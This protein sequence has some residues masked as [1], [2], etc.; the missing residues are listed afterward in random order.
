MPVRPPLRLAAFV[1]D[2]VSHIQH[3]L[4]R[5]P[6]ARQHEFDD[7]RMWIDLAKTLERGRF[8]TLFFADV[9]GLYGPA[10]GDYTVNAREG[11]QVPNADPSILAAALAT[12]TEHLGLAFT[13]SVLQAHP[14]EFA[15]RVSTLD[16]LSRGRIGWNIV[17]S[18]LDGAA[19]NFGHDRLEEHDERYAWAQEYVD[20]VAKLW[21]GSWDDD[22]F[23][24]DK[25]AG[26]VSDASGIH[27]IDHVGQRYRVAG[28]HLS[29]PSPQRTPVL[30]QA[31]SSPAGRAFAARNAEAQFILT[32]TR[33]KTAEL[34]ASTRADVAAAGRL[35]EDLLFFLGLTFVIGST[36][37]EA[38]RRSAEIDELLSPDGFLLHSN[39]GYDPETGAA[40]DPDTP[41]SQ[42]KTQLG[43]S[44]LQWLRE[45]SPDREPTI[46]DLAGLSAKL[47]ARV[48]GTPEQIADELEQWQDIG[49]DGINVMN[50]W[51]PGSYEEFVDHVV[52]TLQDR[53][54][55]QRE[56]AEGTLRR[57]LFGHDQLPDRHPA[58]RWRGAFS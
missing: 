50:W 28:P 22:A 21:E 19:R 4:W 12:H 39:L 32:S 47:R 48:V 8:D 14:F 38:R 6:E 17:T 1:M 24:A 58:R 30:F 54:L 31:G 36:E 23:R 52:P 51:L 56:Y 27:R 44:H 13:S 9:V 2:T 7:V 25:A 42:V 35:P 53:G 10:D 41:L 49:V 55:V 46:R 16:H 45:A 33:E 29:K 37:E 40:L 18:A 5:H 43:Q 3:G 11:L 26:V 15:R 57:K 20:V 34:I